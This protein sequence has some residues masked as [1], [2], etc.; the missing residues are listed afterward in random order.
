[1]YTLFPEVLTVAARC[2]HVLR[3]MRDPSSERWNLM[4]EKG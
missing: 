2:L 3:D 1:M 4:G